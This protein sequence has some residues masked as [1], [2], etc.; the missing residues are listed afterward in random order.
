MSEGRDIRD[1][2]RRLMATWKVG[3]EKSS[4]RSLSMWLNGFPK[5]HLQG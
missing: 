2:R 4:Y 3:R 1:I 5:H